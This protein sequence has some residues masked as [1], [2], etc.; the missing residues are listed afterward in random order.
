MPFSDATSMYSEDMS[1]EAGLRVYEDVERGERMI[2]PGASTLQPAIREGIAT[3][4]LWY[5]EPMSF[6][7][8]P[9]ARFVIRL[10]GS[11]VAIENY[12]WEYVSTLQAV[13]YTGVRLS[14]IRQCFVSESTFD[15]LRPHPQLIISVYE[16]QS[17]VQGPHQTTIFAGSVTKVLTNSDPGVKG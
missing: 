17:N 5:H 14:R 13:S 16:L 4:Q 7:R 6:A 15:V 3:V 11:E 12:Q 10:D 1:T 2:V 8:L 9:N